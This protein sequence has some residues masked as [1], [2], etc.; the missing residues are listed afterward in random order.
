MIHIFIYLIEASICLSLLYVVYLIFIND[1]FYNLKR[2]Y[3]LVSIIVSLIIPQLPAAKI[4]K[5]I[6][7]KIVFSTISNNELSNYSDTFEKVVFGSIPADLN[8]QSFYEANDKNTYLLIILTIYILGISILLYKFLINLNQIYNLVKKNLKEKYFNYTIVYHKVNLSTF[9]FFK[10]IFLNSDNIDKNENQTVLKHEKLHIKYGHSVDIIFMELCK[11]VFWF[12]PIIWIYK[13]SLLKVHECQVDN[14]LI[15]NK[16][17]DINNYQE[18]LLKQYLSNIN[19]ELAHPF[20]YSLI[21]FRIKMMKK[22]KSKWWAKYKMIFAVPVV[23][24]SLLAFSNAN[25]K[26]SSENISN[27]GNQK[28]F[29]ETQPWGMVFIP[30]GSFVLKRTDGSKTKEFNVSVDAFWMKE[31]EVRVE[32]Y[33]DY[34]ESIKKD[35]TRQVYEA[36]LPNKDKVPFEDYFISKDYL[37][38][39]VVGISLKQVQDYCIWLTRVENQKLKNE[40]KPPV[41]DYRIPTEIEWIY[42]SFGGVNPNEI[43]KPEISDLYEIKKGEFKKRDFN[44]WGL[45][46]MF[47]NVSEWTNSY[48]DSEKY[49]NELPNNPNNNYDQV[50]VKGN[51]Y[52][53]SA[54]DEKQIL[55]GADAYDYVGF[56]YVRTYLGKQYGEK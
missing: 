30:M 26:F 32:E 33:L 20:N 6:E 54:T 52:K 31:T 21:K 49:M 45:L 28:Q 37:K 19:I 42:A 53:Y 23:I 17:E 2:F 16:T 22:S 1:T 10:Y 18:L 14:Y 8:I 47:D 27:I 34:L 29:K 51:N 13:K 3:L 4:H 24:I 9:S 15:D 40:G 46:S 39:P 36:A 44:N 11:I 38:Y 5:S 56:R 7:E 41:A 25:I 48:F 35:S 50:I 55:N 43:K 12:N